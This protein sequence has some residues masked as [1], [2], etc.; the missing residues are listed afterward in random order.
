[1]KE[2]LSFDLESVLLEEYSIRESLRAKTVRLNMTPQNGLVIV[3]PAGFNRKRLPDILRE[4]KNWIENAR[5][6]ADE[7]RLL[8]PPMLIT[9]PD[10][11]SLE[12]INEVWT[13]FYRSTGGAR[14]SAREH[15][16]FRLLVSGDADQIAASTMALRRWTSRK[17]RNYLIPWLENLSIELEMPFAD[18]AVRNQSTRW[19]SCSPEKNISL[20]QKLLLLPERLVHYV[21]VHEL[22][23]TVHLNH[24]KRFW[25]LVGRKEPEFKTLRHELGDAWKYVP[26]W[27]EVS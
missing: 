16:D 24:S 7:Q 23:H 3:V 19:A 18:A 15:S 14:T 25:A 1:M 6:W 9:R 11:I 27:L 17:A 21:L 22:C 20:N 13:V 8:K 4:K 10:T 26:G 2:Q 5:R 12:A